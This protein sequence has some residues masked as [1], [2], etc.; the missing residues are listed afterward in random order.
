VISESEKPL[1]LALASLEEVRLASAIHDLR[2]LSQTIRHVEEAVVAASEHVRTLSSEVA[3]LVLTWKRPVVP[4]ISRTSGFV[5]AEP[6]E[7]EG[8]GASARA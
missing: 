1:A 7:K 5:I 2:K 6:R 4:A 3:L 8:L